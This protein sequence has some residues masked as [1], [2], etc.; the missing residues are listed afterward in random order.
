MATITLTN[1]TARVTRVD[2]MNYAIAHLT[3]APADVMEKLTAIRDSFNRKPS[4]A[5]TS[6]TAKENKVLAQAVAAY[7]ASAWDESE[8]MAINARAIVSAIPSITTTQKAVAVANMAVSNG[9]MVK[10]AHKGRTYYAPA[11]TVI[12]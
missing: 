12:A 10:F 8:P 2:A 7:V 11:G 3:D 4:A 1:N 5:T 6:K 9:E